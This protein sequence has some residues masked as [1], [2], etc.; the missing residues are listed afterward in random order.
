[1]SGRAKLAAILT[2]LAV[3]GG[4]Y[5]A[6]VLAGGASAS[7]EQRAK[8]LSDPLADQSLKI[9]WKTWTHSVD[10]IRAEPLGT[11]LGTVGHATQEGRARVVHRQLVPQGAFRSRGSSEGFCSRWG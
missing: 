10:K 6:A 4:M 11:G 2:G 1:M 8:G 3:A 5:G 9:R 7:T